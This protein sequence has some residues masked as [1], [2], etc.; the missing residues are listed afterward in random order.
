MPFGPELLATP[1]GLGD[2]LGCF[3]A[4]AGFVHGRPV[5]PP[6]LNFELKNGGDSYS[7][8][9]SLHRKMIPGR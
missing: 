1:W 9:S 8:P 4:A 2:G 3:G 7:F 6:W 5:P